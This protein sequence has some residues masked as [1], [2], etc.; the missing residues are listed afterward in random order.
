MNHSEEDVTQ[1][2]CALG[3]TNQQFPSDEII[4]SEVTDDDNP[5]SYVRIDT[6]FGGDRDTCGG[7]YG[8]SQYLLNVHLSKA[9]KVKVQVVFDNRETTYPEY[10]VNPQNRV[11]IGCTQWRHD[12]GIQYYVRKI[13][14]ADFV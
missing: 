14:A 10:T 9:I 1:E 4:S 6:I 11:H 3:Y 5:L 8:D 13:T 7:R 12:Y 2:M